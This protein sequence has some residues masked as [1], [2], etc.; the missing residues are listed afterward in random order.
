MT[1]PTGY[2]SAPSAQCAALLH[3]SLPAHEATD[4]IRRANA[5]RGGAVS[6]ARGGQPLTDGGAR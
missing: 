3:G 1:T 5:S 6:A 2:V 4:G